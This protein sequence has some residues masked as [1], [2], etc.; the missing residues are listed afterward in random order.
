MRQEYKIIWIED[1]PDEIR[2]HKRLVNEEVTKHY[3]KLV[4]IDNI[5]TSISKFEREI[6]NKYTKEDFSDFD[7]MIIDY[8]LSSEL[9]GKDLIKKIREKGIYTDI[10]FYSGNLEGLKKALLP[11][12][13]D[14]VVFSD[15]NREQ[16]IQKFQYIINKQ[17]NLKMGISDIRGYLMDSTSD[18]DFIIKNFSTTFFEKLSDVD[19]QKVIEK[20]KGFIEDQDKLEQAKFKDVNKKGGLKLIKA[21]MDSQEYVM[22]VRNKFYIFSLIYSLVN[23]KEFEFVEKS[24]NDYDNNIIKPRNKLAHAKLTYGKNFKNH[25]KISKSIEDLACCCDECSGK[26]TK[27]ECDNI[28]KNIYE[29]YIFLE[30]T[31][32]PLI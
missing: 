15:S 1:E 32:K 8:N 2:V 4:G 18:F 31:A 14:G 28:R 13:L 19:Q 22:S 24:T 3:L 23:K 30:A 12:E 11:A 5:Y 16:F 17:L 21:A 29:A 27:E 20:V 7:L 9:T 26:Y 25:I 6:L 10:L